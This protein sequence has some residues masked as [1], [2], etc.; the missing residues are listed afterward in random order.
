MSSEIVRLA[1]G[2]VQAAL[3]E[4]DRRLDETMS[5]EARLAEELEHVKTENERVSLEQ[6]K[7]D[8]RLSRLSS[9]IAKTKQIIAN[10]QALLVNQ[11]KAREQVMGELEELES[12]RQLIVGSIQEKDRALKEARHTVQDLVSLSVEDLRREILRRL[13]LK[14]AEEIREVES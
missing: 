2:E 11:E 4:S 13:E 1:S 14:R 3:E 10:A 7:V 8:S 9:E 12:R 6:Q 5:L